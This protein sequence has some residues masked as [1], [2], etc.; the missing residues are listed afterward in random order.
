MTISG[1]GSALSFE[2]TTKGDVLVGDVGVVVLLVC[3]CFW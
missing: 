1:S 3:C 2:L